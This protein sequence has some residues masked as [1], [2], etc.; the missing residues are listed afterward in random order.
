[1]HYIVTGTGLTDGQVEA[2]IHHSHTEM[3]SAAAAIRGNVPIET[4]FEVQ[5]AAAG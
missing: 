5:R 3:C 4:L 1:M 2:A